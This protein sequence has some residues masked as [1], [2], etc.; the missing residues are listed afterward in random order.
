MQKTLKKISLSLSQKSKK[1]SKKQGK[2]KEKVF[3]FI[4]HG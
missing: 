4:L 3:R 1:I 2:Q